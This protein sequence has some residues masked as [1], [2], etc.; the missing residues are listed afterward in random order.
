MTEQDIS[1]LSDEQLEALQGLV[2]ERDMLKT[3]TPGPAKAPLPAPL[4][5][6]GKYLDPTRHAGETFDQRQRR[7]AQSN[8]VNEEANAKMFAKTG[9]FTPNVL[10]QNHPGGGQLNIKDAG[11]LLGAMLTPAAGA[12]GTGLSSRGIATVIP[13]GADKVPALLGGLSSA[14][15]ETPADLA[16]LAVT[17]G[18]ANALQGVKAASR[19][20]NIANRAAQGYLLGEAGNQT[21]AAVSRTKVGDGVGIPNQSNFEVAGKQ[22]GR[23][24]PSL[25]PLNKSFS[26]NMVQLLSAGIGAAQGMH[27]FPKPAAIKPKT[28]KELMQEWEGNQ[29]ARQA[30]KQK[31]DDINIKMSDYKT[32][33]AE[34]EEE[35]K[36]LRA[37]AKTATETEK[38]AFHLKNSKL[39]EQ[40]K[41]IKFELDAAKKLKESNQAALDTY[42]KGNARGAKALGGEDAEK[43]A[44]QILGLQNQLDDLRG[45]TAVLD[46]SDQ[47]KKIK[48]TLA[49]QHARLE[50]P[51]YQSE[52]QQ[53]SIKKFITRMEEQLEDELAAMDEGADAAT[54]Q[55]I[56]ETKAQIREL[57]VA[58]KRAE[59]GRTEPATNV[60]PA[61]EKLS[62]LEKAVADSGKTAD[63]LNKKYQRTILERLAASKATPGKG[64]QDAIR[65]NEESA[66]IYRVTK[67]KLEGSLARLAKAEPPKVKRPKDPPSGLSHALQTI[68]RRGIVPALA[69]STYYLGN[70]HPMLGAL[71]A[72]ALDQLATTDT[73]RKLMEFLT[74]RAGPSS[75]QMIP[76]LVNEAAKP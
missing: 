28:Y 56:T 71:S 21:N 61:D 22:H 68:T 37:K 6:R 9:M 76:S 54:Q 59:K 43:Y 16:T 48:S 58:Q 32:G 52:G 5:P 25:N 65:Q 66:G 40:E 27:E 13:Q 45:G 30:H 49:D 12:V 42:Q 24:Q 35:T 31:V 64:I 50:N 36:A 39:R 23:E 34:V 51:K 11:S 38:A 74:K 26:D 33:L 62:A 17:G 18:A 10:K 41:A 29:A 57:K 69:G 44:D 2:T 60:A 4:D 1:Q 67:S 46:E 53:T 47:I 7:L 75:T 15:T 63:G 70:A 8:K 55:K 14:T 73:G 3:A 72:A 20:A 19:G